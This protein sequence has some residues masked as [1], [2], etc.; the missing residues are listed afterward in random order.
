[1][2]ADRAA[3]G[4]D[5]ADHVLAFDAAHRTSASVSS[6]TSPRCAG[7]SS[8]TIR[9]SSRKSSLSTMKSAD[10]AAS[11]I[12]PRRGVR[13]PDLRAGVDPPQDLVP[14][15]CSRRLAY[16]KAIDPEDPPLRPERHIPNSIATTSRPFDQRACED[17][18]AMSLLRSQGYNV[19]ATKVMTQ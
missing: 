16:P 7:V 6:S 18:A 4:R 8:G 11:I 17:P 15:R 1:M 14:P 19:Q 10:G 5:R 12:T 2:V 3:R 9:S 13:I